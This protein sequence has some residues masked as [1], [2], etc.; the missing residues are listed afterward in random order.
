M[1]LTLPASSNHNKLMTSRTKCCPSN[2]SFKDDELLKKFAREKRPIYRQISLLRPIY[3][4]QM[5]FHSMLNVLQLRILIC[6]CYGSMFY[7]LPQWFYTDCKIVCSIVSHNRYG[8]DKRIK[9]K[10]SI[11]VFSLLKESHGG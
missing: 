1:T 2:S 9:T 10:K 7:L 6:F 3:H 8:H 5:K 11:K 4:Y